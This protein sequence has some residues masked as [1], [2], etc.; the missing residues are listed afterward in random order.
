MRG[1]LKV[2]F[3]TVLAPY[4]CR[5]RPNQKQ[6]LKR[7]NHLRNTPSGATF[8]NLDSVRMAFPI[9]GPLPVLASADTKVAQVPVQ[10]PAVEL[11][12]L[13]TTSLSGKRRYAGA[14]QL[15]VTESRQLG[16]R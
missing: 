6:F 3:A 4:Q 7:A 2:S 13:P 16:S 5:R 10:A 8:Y 1:S 14:T 15:F 11:L 12:P 9:C